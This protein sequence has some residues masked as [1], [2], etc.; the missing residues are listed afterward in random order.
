MAEP[1][2]NASGVSQAGL[3]GEALLTAVQGLCAGDRQSAATLSDALHR[4]A[5]APGAWPAQAKRLQRRGL[6]ANYQ[7]A[8][9]REILDLPGDL[10]LLQLQGGGLAL[11]HKSGDRWQMLNAAG[12]PVADVAES[13]GDAYTEGVVLRMPARAGEPAATINLSALWH[14]LRAAWAELGLASLFIN[15]GL[16]LLPLF[17]MIVYDK[18]VSNAVYETL[19][20]LTIGM[21]IY[22]VAD[23]GMRVVRALSTE[24]IAAE[25]T[26]RGDMF[27]WRRLTA[28]SD[29]ASAFARFLSHYRDLA[30]ARE[31]VSSTY[32][33]AIADLPFLFLYLLAIGIIA[34]P[35]AVVSMLL[36]TIYAGAG[37]VLQR[38]INAQ[39]REAEQLATVKLTFMGEMLSAMDVVQT[40]P[41]RGFF[42]RRWHEH[43]EQTA[44]ADGRRRLLSSHAGTMAACMLTLSTVSM[45]V[46]GAYLIEMRVLSVG[47][48]I[49]CSL[50]NSRAMSL[51]SSLFMVIGKWQD[52]QRAAQRVD[53]ML[54]PPESREPTPCPEVAGSINVIGLAKHYPGRPVALDR[55][56]FKVA[57][58][59]RIGL[60]GR[61]GAGKTT[62]LRCLAHLCIPDQGQILIDGLD[63]RDIAPADRARWMAWKSQDPALFAGTLEE[64]LRVSGSAS[65]SERLRL[66]LWTSGLEDEFNS[67]R[68]SLGMKLDERGSN[69]S[70]GQRQKVALARAFA[71]PCRILLLDEPTLG[72]DPDTERQLAERLPGLL[73]PG[74]L[75]IMTTHSAIMLGMVNRVIAL[76][77][78]RIVADGPREQLLRMG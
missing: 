63:Q 20:A 44:D 74:D 43:V 76:D 47:G 18:V 14:A 6:Q 37:Y 29:L 21:M 38:R 7:S 62:L 64:N 73:G 39:S 34:W 71:Q 36:V 48:L 4:L 33:L 53:G 49:A 67:G 69:L 12:E 10:A 25:L 72:L 78:G 22:L 2:S 75:L 50:L 3:S 54:H 1:T 52:F 27:L 55:I 40:A 41:G 30:V 23:A 26:R 66:A 17:S 57:P 11:L 19:W 59:E 24:H 60:L 68:M 15:T 28:Q 58:G 70:G 56:S 61:P 46:A 45:L 5:S 77:G 32:L 31:F 65:G 8:T 9:L 16:L 51:V 35:L 13:A 42:R